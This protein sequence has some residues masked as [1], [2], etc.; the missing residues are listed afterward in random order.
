MQTV[1]ARRLCCPSPGTDLGSAPGYFPS[2]GSRVMVVVRIRVRV[3][4]VLIRS[5]YG[6][7]TEDSACPIFIRPADGK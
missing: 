3:S 6:W 5:G 4:V 2:A 7:R 1:F